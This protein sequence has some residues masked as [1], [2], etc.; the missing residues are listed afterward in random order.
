MD[1]L[2]SIVHLCEQSRT[3]DWFPGWDMDEAEAFMFL[4]WQIRKYETWDVVHDMLPLAIVQRDTNAF[5]GHCGIGK[6]EALPETELSIGIEKRYRNAGYATEAVNALTD[7][8]FST[9][10]IPFLCATILVE[11]LASQRVFERCGYTLISTVELDYPEP[12]TPFKYYRRQ[13]ETR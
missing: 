2:D 13:R 6:H 9:F 10:E 8:A 12:G 11:N 4:E 3:G 7:W 5:I 1:D